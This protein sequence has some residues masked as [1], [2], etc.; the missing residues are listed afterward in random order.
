MW[1]RVCVSRPK[2]CTPF[3]FELNG[4]NRYGALEQTLGAKHHELLDMQVRTL[5]KTTRIL[6]QSGG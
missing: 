4:A 6:K 2:I 5:K 3:A 1:E